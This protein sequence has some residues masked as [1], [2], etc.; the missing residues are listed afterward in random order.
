MGYSFTKIL[1]A[2]ETSYVLTASL[3]ASDVPRQIRWH[4]AGALRIG[5]TVDEIRAVREM[6]KEVAI[7]AGVQWRDEVPDV[8]DTNV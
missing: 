6:A 7:R 1:S 2:L 5:A 4:L 8:E 3:I